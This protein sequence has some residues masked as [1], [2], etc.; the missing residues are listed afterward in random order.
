M[1]YVIAAIFAATVLWGPR[2]SASE[3][4]NLS[5]LKIVEIQTHTSNSAS[6]EFI[7]L[8]NTRVEP[9]SLDGVVVQYKSK[10][11]AT[12][13]T[14]SSL[15]GEIAPFGRILM[16]THF[17]EGLV[18][19]GGLANSSGHVR[20]V[21]G[22]EI[23]DTVGWGE[24][25]APEEEAATAHTQAQ[26]I[27]RFVDEDGYFIDTQNNAADWFVSETPS[28]RHDSWMSVSSSEDESVDDLTETGDVEPSATSQTASPL[29]E[30]TNTTQPSPSLPLE[31][32]ELMPDPVS[33]LTDADHEFIELYNPNDSAVDLA[34]YKLESG[35]DGRYS[36][37]LGEYILA[38][39]EYLSVY[40]V[41]TGLVLSNS[42]STVELLGPDGV[43]HDQ[44]EYAKAKPGVSWSK[45]GGQWGWA[46]ATN[47]T[48]NTSALSSESVGDEAQSIEKKTVD[49]ASAA[50]DNSSEPSAVQ[51]TFSDDQG[52]EERHVNNWVLAG[53]GSLAVLY[54]LYEY[55]NDIRLRIQQCRRYFEVRRENRTK[56]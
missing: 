54:A 27:K 42:G 30:A 13:V 1:K 12:W 41:D 56:S 18:F 23:I 20:I 11:G 39:G 32:T 51:R 2:A 17:E 37:I 14:K 40:S 6:E 35:E 25:D 21:S 33:P 34:G 44:T 10:S 5:A 52:T 36:H 29:P 28:P 22:D 53:M 15:T 24:A 16:S 47:N 46:S 43:V 19:S 50:T 48:E 45:V 38:P 3:E 7:E 49:Y 26:S 8:A 9:V 55:R 31:I 4:Q